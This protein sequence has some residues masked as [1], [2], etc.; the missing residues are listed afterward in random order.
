MYDVYIKYN[1]YKVATDILVN[2][3]PV[4]PSSNLNYG[5]RRL[6]EWVDDLPK[7]LVI[8]LRSDEFK[9]T[10]KGTVLDYEDLCASIAVANKDGVVTEEGQ[11][12]VKVQI[13]AVR[14]PAK[15]VAD[16]EKQIAEIFSD[17]QEGP[18]EELRQPDV[19]QAFKLAQT[20]D[21]PINVIATMSAGKSTLINA[22]LGR[23][24]MP[25]SQEACTATI[26]E[27]KDCDDEY[28]YAEA[29]DA[30]DNL[31]DT[32]PALTLEQMKEMNNDPN[33]SKILVRGDIPFVSSDDVQLVLVDTP[34][35]NNARNNEHRAATMRALSKS[36]KTLV[37]YV[38]NAT[39]LGINDEDMF[40]SEVA[41]SMKVNGRQSRDRFIFVVNKL[42]TFKQDEDSVEKSIQRVREYL[43][44]KKIMDANIYPASALTALNIRTLLKDIDL[45]HVD[46][47]TLDDDTYDAVGACRKMNRSAEK[48]LE[49]YAPLTPSAKSEIAGMLAD[50]AA[51][52]DKKQEALIHSGIP[53]I[54]A[55]IRT[56]V[57]K[58]AK[59][60]KIK[61]IVDTFS[62]KLESQR[63]LERTR[64]EI[65]ESK[66][67]RQAVQAQI[68]I[69]KQK[70]ADGENAKAFKSRI[71]SL[72]Y[73]K[74]INKM[75]REI[76]LDYQKAIRTT[77]TDSF[78]GAKRLSVSEAESKAK[79]LSKT[80]ET[81]IAKAQVALEEGVSAKLAEA[82][83]ELLSQ[84]KSKL[85]SLT[86][87]LGDIDSI[88][89]DPLKLLEGDIDSLLNYSKFLSDSK[90]VESEWQVVGNHKEY[91]EIVGLRRFL[92]D[93]LGTNFKVN[94]EIVDD[95]DWVD[96]EFVDVDEFY[97]KY[98]SPIQQRLMDYSDAS[99]EYAKEQVRETKKK[100]SKVF[101]DLD[102][103]LKRKM[104]ELDT[105]Q[106]NETEIQAMLETAE[107]NLRWLGDIQHRIDAILDI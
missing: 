61:G 41:D 58:Y 26:T 44:G 69:L 35:P 100:F 50:A 70:M 64:Q 104:A 77:L 31:I 96:V 80:M 6:Q 15:E 71:D 4:K 102:K 22:L 1:P 3:Q 25:A 73:D 56:Y 14:E 45:A 68:E 17:I 23:A 97:S 24:L 101:D 93:H 94:Y 7:H 67:K 72:N 52:G 16:K 92:N 40:I 55:A 21:F 36:S 95:Y 99:S 103:L 32:R 59:T 5:T 76:V 78:Q 34:G 13:T 79:A 84:Y 54:E 62:A 90:K 82:V 87:D 30:H 42:D 107:R 28:F 91:D 85:K 66:E 65:A 29:Y 12:A 43:E 37:L 9:I 88:G 20:S 11:P 38:M 8:E 2:G 106:K 60:A 105:S 19:V 46:A 75:A 18:F 89:I 33:V 39:A 81:I 86:E 83:N 98:T 63:S 27:I 51:R 74:E 57:Q 10:F 49:T 47:D 48:H 53:S